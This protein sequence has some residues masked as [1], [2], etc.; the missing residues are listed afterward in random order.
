[1]YRAYQQYAE[2]VERWRKEDY[3]QIRKLAKRAGATI[4]FEDELAVRSDY[5]SGMTWA[6]V[7][8]TPVVKATGARFRVNLISAISAQ[9][10]LRFMVTD[11]RLTAAVFIEFLKRL[12]HGAEAPIFLILD[13]HP[14][15]RSTKVK[16][17]VAS[18]DGMLCLF[19]LPSYSPELNPDEMVWNHLKRHGIGKTAVTGPDNLK[20]KVIAHL[21]SLQML[22]EL[23]RS[24]FRERHVLYASA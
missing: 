3:P 17:F 24:F 13:G 18:T 1:L 8:K 21:R 14:V 22:P 10:A 2:A 5:H 19:F 6:A 16:K 7:G 9:G 23:V 20:R 4:Y 11:K 12:L 15:H